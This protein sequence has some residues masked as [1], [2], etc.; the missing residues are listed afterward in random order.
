MFSPCWWLIILSD[1]DENLITGGSYQKRIHSSWKKLIFMWWKFAIVSLAS[2]SARLGDWSASWAKEPEE[3][4]QDYVRRAKMLR[5]RPDEELAPE[6]QEAL[7]RSLKK[8]L[9]VTTVSNQLLYAHILGEL[10]TEDFH[11][12]ASWLNCTIHLFVQTSL[13]SNFHHPSRSLPFPI[14]PCIEIVMGHW[15]DGI[16]Y[17]LWYVHKN[18]SLNRINGCLK[19]CL[20]SSNFI[21]PQPIR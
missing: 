9:T 20:S 15:I 7:V 2:G 19:S 8:Q 4:R 1:D 10:C 14:H 11:W 17:G 16:N 6:E 5:I 3:V 21:E 12:L 18:E 13:T